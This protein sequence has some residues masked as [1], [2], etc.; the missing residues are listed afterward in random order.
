MEQFRKLLSFLPADRLSARP[1]ERFWIIKGMNA[2]EVIA[3]KST[4]AGIIND[5]IRV[6]TALHN[7]GVA[8]DQNYRKRINTLKRLKRQTITTGETIK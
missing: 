7:A 1:A 8:P 4:D 6:M 3:M 2:F 5:A